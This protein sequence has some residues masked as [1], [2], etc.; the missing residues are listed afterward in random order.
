[1]TNL[2]QALLSCICIAIPEYIFI[3]IL[4]LRFIGRK[5]LLDFYNLKNNLKLILRIVIPPAIIINILNYIVLKTP[6]NSLIAL[7][8]LYSLLIYTL[9]KESFINYPK[10]YIKTFLFFLLSILISISIEMISLPI[11]FK[12]INMNYIEIQQ[13]FSLVL[14]CSLASRIIDIIILIYIFINKNSK[15]QINMSDYIF[16]NKFFMRLIVSLGLALILFEGYIIK[17]I[18]HNNLLNIVN[19]VYEQLFIVIGSTFLIPSILILIVYTCINYCIMIIN[20]EKQSN[21]ND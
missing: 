18:L 14:L 20:S 1:M 2:I 12:L 17:L 10:L 6:F 13:N 4:T 9:K 3:T 19:S 15:F 5:D 21:L 7:V 16:R 8:I 11:I